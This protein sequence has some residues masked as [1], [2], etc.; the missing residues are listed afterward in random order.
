M[1]GLG[2]LRFV[3]NGALTLLLGGYALHCSADSDNAG[4]AA[5]GGGG[6]GA[7]GG[8]GGTGADLKYLD[9]VCTRMA[10]A[11]NEAVTNLRPARLKIATRFASDWATPQFT[12]AKAASY[13]TVRIESKS[14]TAAAT[15]AWEPRGWIRPWFKCLVVA[16]SSGSL[17]PGDRI[18]VTLGDTSGGSPGSRAQTFRERG[19]E[20]LV[21]VDPFG[22][23]LYTPLASSPKVNVVGGGLMGAP[24]SGKRQ[25]HLPTDVAELLQAM[26]TPHPDRIFEIEAAG[27]E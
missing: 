10:E 22:T 13:T 24:G 16:I 21:L 9:S 1:R 17:H 26:A 25:E 3:R 4:G 14:G 12:D 6:S 8:K 11:V 18:H 23:E 7:K 2:T 20:F 15:L 27:N 19:A 5:N